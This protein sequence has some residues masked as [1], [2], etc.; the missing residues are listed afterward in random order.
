MAGRLA[1]T[2]AKEGVP[3]IHD[4]AAQLQQAASHDPDLLTT[5][6][7]TTDLLELCRS[8]QSSYLSVAAPA[9]SG[10]MK[11]GP[12]TCQATDLHCA[13]CPAHLAD[14]LYG[15]GRLLGVFVGTARATEAGPG[16]GRAGGREAGRFL[17][18]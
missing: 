12:R 13:A 2:A 8:T 1:A 11:R 18:A 6:K 9:R 4:L 17:R 16:P 10:E 14:R 7:L 15:P 5:V 3:E